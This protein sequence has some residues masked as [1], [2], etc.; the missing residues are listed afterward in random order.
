MG[1]VPSDGFVHGCITAALALG[2]VVG[3]WTTPTGLKALLTVAFA[4]AYSLLGSY[5]RPVCEPCLVNI[6]CPPCVSWGNLFGW[7]LGTAA[8]SAGIVNGVRAAFVRT[9][10]A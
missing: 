2:L 8:A 1:L 5:A 7:T 4:L 9:N 3:V 10:P 6:Q